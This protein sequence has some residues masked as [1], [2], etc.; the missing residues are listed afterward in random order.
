MPTRPPTTGSKKLVV[1]GYLDKHFIGTLAHLYT[2]QYIPITRTDG[3]GKLLEDASS[4]V[5]SAGCDA[6]G[7]V[8]DADCDA[9]ANYSKLRR[10]LWDACGIDLPPNL[11]ANGVIVCNSQ[12]KSNRNA[13][14]GVYIMPDNKSAGQIEDFIIKMIPNG[15][16]VFRLAKA[17]IKEVENG[18]HLK[19]SSVKATLNAWLS[20]REN[21]R[22]NLKWSY[23]ACDLDLRAPVCESFGYWIRGLFLR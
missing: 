19:R 10:T 21:P 18:G 17:Y 22:H 4:F 9:Y 1:E 23:P 2:K 5:K 15:D 14:V 8:I 3:I 7:F 12:Q 13:R 20:V 6:L 11:S 16:P